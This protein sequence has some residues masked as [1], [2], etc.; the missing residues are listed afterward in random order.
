MK[1]WHDSGGCAKVG[2]PNEP[3]RKT[4]DQTSKCVSSF[5]WAT[6]VLNEYLLEEEQ[7]E[8]GDCQWMSILRM[9]RSEEA[10]GHS[11][12]GDEFPA[13]DDLRPKRTT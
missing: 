2:Q 12:A 11:E 10:A 6:Y 13:N 4:V 9:E 1:L 7:A 5:V 8:E 3:L